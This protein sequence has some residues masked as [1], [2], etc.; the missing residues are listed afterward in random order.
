ME[1]IQFSI[2][3][4]K[5]QYFKNK[6]LD[7]NKLFNNFLEEEISKN[8]FLRAQESSLRKI[9]DNEEDKIWDDYL[10]K[11]KVQLKQNGC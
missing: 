7:M 10:E 9:W 1:S 5:V 3:D 4:E 2:S 6:N 8:E 11:Y